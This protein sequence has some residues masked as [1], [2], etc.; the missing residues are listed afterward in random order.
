MLEYSISLK[1]NKFK[2][3][4]RLLTRYSNLI[5][6]L[7]FERTFEDLTNYISELMTRQNF[8][9]PTKRYVSVRMSFLLYFE[10]KCVR[11]VYFLKKEALLSLSR[12]AER[13]FF[14][15]VINQ[16]TSG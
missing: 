10:T 14:C 15:S 2:F 9:H 7:N 6:Q 13:S 8:F 16:F 11:F 5:D 12:L 3:E 1:G 4:H